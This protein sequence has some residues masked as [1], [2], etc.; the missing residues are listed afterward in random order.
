MSGGTSAS[1]QL[2]VKR[3]KEIE[4]LR[5]KKLGNRLTSGF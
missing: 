5:T 2:D 1:R 4:F 3:L